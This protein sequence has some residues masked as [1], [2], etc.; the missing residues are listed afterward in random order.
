MENKKTNYIWGLLRIVMGWIFLWAFI[1]KM[2]GLGFTTVPDKAWLVGGSP[3][4]GFL[5]FAAYGPFESL[6]NSMA[7]SVIVDWLFMLGL[8]LVGLAL[9]LGILTKL[10][11]FFGSVMLLLMWSACLPPEHNPLIDEHIIYIIILIGVVMSRAG[12]YIGLGNRWSNTKLVKKFTIF[13]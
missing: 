11:T 3:T 13:E 5:H 8:L 9:A 2:F 10:A 4:F 7:G 6:F 1:D 12:Q